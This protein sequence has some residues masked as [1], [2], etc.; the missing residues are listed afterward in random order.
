MQ[1]V[2]RLAFLNEAPRETVHFLMDV[3]QRV[4]FHNDK[5]NNVTGPYDGH[6]ETSTFAVEDSFT[7]SAT[8]FAIG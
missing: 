7:V 8:Y 5:E 2:R 4:L 3:F 1:T 6:R